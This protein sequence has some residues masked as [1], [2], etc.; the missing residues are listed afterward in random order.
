MPEPKPVAK[1]VVKKKHAVFRK[2]QASGV[3]RKRR[4]YCVSCGEE[5]PE[6]GTLHGWT[7][8]GY[9]HRVVWTCSEQCAEAYEDYQHQAQAISL[10][11]VFG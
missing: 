8:R 5:K 9:G 10:K 3:K 7:H 1:P 6:A 11:D 2:D 4:P